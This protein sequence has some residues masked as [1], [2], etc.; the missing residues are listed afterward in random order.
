MIRVRLLGTLAI[1]DDDVEIELA[2]R[3]ERRLIGLLGLSAGRVCQRRDVALSLWPEVDFEVSGNR[4]RTTLVALKKAFGERDVVE[5]TATT[6]RLAG[7]VEVDLDQVKRVMDRVRLT[8][9]SRVLGNLYHELINALKPGLLVGVHDEWLHMYQDYWSGVLQ[10]VLHKAAE[11][12]FDHEQYIRASELAAQAVERQLDDALGW[13]I[14]LR[15][16]AKLGEGREAYRKFS[17]ARRRVRQEGWLEFEQSLGQL[18]KEVRDGDHAINPALWPLPPGGDSVLVR[19]FQRMAQLDRDLAAKF[20]TSDAF[21]LEAFRSPEPSL[22]IVEQLADSLAPNDPNRPAVLLM[23]MRIHSLLHNSERVIQLSEDLLAAELT[24]SQRRL[25]LT[26]TSF[27][28]FQL[29]QFDSALR[30]VDEALEIAQQHLKPYQIQL[31]LADKAHYLWHL[32]DFEAALSCFESVLTAIAE[33]PEPLVSYAPALLHGNIGAIHVHCGRLAQGLD[34]LERGHSLA[35]S[36]RYREQIHQIEAPLGFTLTALGRPTEGRKAILSSLTH[37]FRTRNQRAL[38]LGLD[39][40]ASALLQLKKAHLAEALFEWTDA[41]RTD[42]RHS[43]TKSETMF[44]GHHRS[45][46]RA[47]S[48]LSGLRLQANNERAVLEV[49]FE[50]IS[51]TGK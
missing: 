47:L 20:V 13:E 32:G 37:F 9:E 31:T 45:R 33:E 42:I 17:A 18:A 6:L 36:G 15:S 29:R 40:T 22:G 51:E 14:F 41:F 4:L 26:V 11:H 34:W 21:R 12:E 8:S 2:G 10:D 5:A 39:Y 44:V 27:A 23:A 1:F 46:A 28:N 16:M 24:P 38:A 30:L 7:S 19:A 35:N 48:P 25:A 43:R 49:I 50:A 3:N